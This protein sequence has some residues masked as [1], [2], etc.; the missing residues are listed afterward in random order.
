MT[1]SFLQEFSFLDVELRYG[2]L[3]VTEALCYLHTTERLLHL[4]IC[5]QNVIVN[6]RG[7][8]KITGLGFAQSISDLNAKVSQ[9]LAAYIDF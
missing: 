3:Q 5:P 9:V 2:I 4:N 6:K 1:C 7:M 8:W